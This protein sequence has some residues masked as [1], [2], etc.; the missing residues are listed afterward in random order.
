MAVGISRSIGIGMKKCC[1]GTISGGGGGGGGGSSTI[2]ARFLGD[3]CSAYEVEFSTDGTN[4]NPVST[5]IS[6]TSQ[7]NPYQQLLNATPGQTVYFRVTA[8]APGGVHC[9]PLNLTY[10]EV[11]LRS[12]NDPVVAANN[13]LRMTVVSTNTQIY[14]F[15]F[16]PGVEDSVHIDAIAV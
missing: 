6:G 10:S 14:S 15:V 13:T 3:T 1:G 16:T 4:Y 2:T 9:Q 8:L 12:G 5:K 7:A 11:T